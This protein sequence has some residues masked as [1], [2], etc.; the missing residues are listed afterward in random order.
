MRSL[1]DQGRDTVQ[2]AEV[3]ESGIRCPLAP[4]RSPRLLRVPFPFKPS[5]S[6]EVPQP[7]G[8]E[9]VL[10][11]ASRGAP[12]VSILNLVLPSLPPQGGAAWDTRCLFCPVRLL[13]PRLYSQ[14]AEGRP[15]SLTFAALS[16][17]LGV[18]GEEMLRCSPSKRRSPA[19]ASWWL[20]CLFL[21]SG[22]A[23]R[24][25]VKTPREKAGTSRPQFH[26][27]HP[28]LLSLPLRFRFRKPA[29]LAAHTSL[30]LTHTHPA[31]A[32]SSVGA[33]GFPVLL[34]EAKLGR[35]GRRNE[36]VYE[37]VGLP[38]SLLSRRALFEI[39]VMA[40][41]TQDP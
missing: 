22:S 1:S 16:G 31:P 38:R 5:P 8:P 20:R 18:R 37:R 39:K 32:Q 28:L 24:L 26:L 14:V 7:W 29:G 10:L 19:S 3:G 15:S 17:F 40:G 41:K 9:C 27:P 13:N 25:F 21:S 2:G 12:H 11:Q 4:Q 30:T 33:I 34:W 6:L 23:R 35:L 36:P